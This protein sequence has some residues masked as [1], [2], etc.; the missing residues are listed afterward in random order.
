M[1][2]LVFDVYTQFS[3]GLVIAFWLED[4]IV[5]KALSSPLLADDV[6]I[7]DAFEELRLAINNQ[8]KDGAPPSASTSNPVSSAKQLT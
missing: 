6:A 3:K 7:T 1:A 8:G 2:Y 5:A 4:G